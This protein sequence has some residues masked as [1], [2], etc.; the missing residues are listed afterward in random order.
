MRTTMELLWNIIQILLD[1]G[2]LFLCCEGVFR[3]ERHRAAK[4]ILLYP[5]LTLFCMAARVSVTAGGRAHSLFHA[6]GFE[7]APADNLFLL[8]FLMLGVLLSASLFFR[9]ADNGSAFWGSVFAF[10][11]YLS[12]RMLGFL[13][14]VLCGGKGNM[15]LLGSR[16][17]SLALG[18]A[19]LLSPV[20]P[21]I[22]QAI[23]N[24]GMG[25]RLMS[26][27]LALV[28]I[29]LLTLYSFDAKRVAAHPGLV[30]SLFLLLLLLDS[31]FMIYSQ[32]RAAEQKRIRMT[33]EYV[34]IVEELISQVRARQHEFQNRLLAMEEAVMAAESLEEARDSV[35]HLAEGMALKPVDR[36]LLSCDSKMIAGMLYGKYRQADYLHLN[37]VVELQSKFKESSLPETGWIELLGILLDNAM[38]ASEEGGR[39][40][41]K[42]IRKD[43]WTELTVSNPFSPMSNTEFM[44]LFRRG[45]TSKGS[46]RESHGFGLHNVQTMMER[47]HGKII[48]RNE[49][50]DGVNYVVF[51]VLV[52]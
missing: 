14:F 40:Y 44:R 34:P 51:G 28:W 10:S 15:L 27:N 24:G 19:L 49:V 52:P 21:W 2:L 46:E 42:A 26:S 3:D 20:F 35:T 9:P 23:E 30:L 4:D 17:L 36:E 1:A 5:I 41:V 45:V 33:E 13:I 43:G 25:A 12:V 38:E 18:A 39:I 32:H 6:Q 29:F 11:I 7:I 16:L 22:K 37:L 8:L 47:F 50:R 48:T 31:C